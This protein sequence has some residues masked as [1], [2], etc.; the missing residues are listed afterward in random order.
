MKNNSPQ[1]R[2]RRRGKDLETA[3]IEIALNELL[4]KGYSSVTIEKIAEQAKTSRTVL[5]RRWKTRNE[6]VV[7]ALDLYIQRHP[8][9]IPNLG[10][11]REELALLLIKVSERG[12]PTVKALFSLSE[13]FDETNS[14]LRELRAKLQTRD[15][16]QEVLQRAV[17]RGEI[18]TAK[19]TNRV[20]TLPLD[21]MR[22]DTYMTG[23]KVSRSSVYEILD[24]IYF[25]LVASKNSRTNKK[26]P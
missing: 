18:D 10:N 24:T 20:L 7:A 16:Y 1:D 11:F 2:S 8:I 12:A 15:I 4:K 26:N 21:L 19:L 22:H 14:T 3:I 23:K 9:D 5:A 6:L 17:N 13:Y 25:P